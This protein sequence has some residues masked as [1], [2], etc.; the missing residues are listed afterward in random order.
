MALGDKFNAYNIPDDE[1]ARAKSSRVVGLTYFPEA[2]TPKEIKKNMSEILGEPYLSEEIAS[3]Y[4]PEEVKA[5]SKQYFDN[6]KEGNDAFVEQLKLR[7]QLTRAYP[8]I[9]MNDLIPNAFSNY[10]VA[11]ERFKKI[12][13]AMKGEK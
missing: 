7:R 13:E 2:S 8:N 4:D 3:H 6:S 10:D 1:L 5:L 9:D 12:R 11:R